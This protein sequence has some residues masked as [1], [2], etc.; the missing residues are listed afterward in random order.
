MQNVFCK[1]KSLRNFDKFPKAFWCTKTT[2]IEN[3]SAVTSQD[4]GGNHLLETIT[5]YTFPA[6]HESTCRL[7][8]FWNIVLR[9]LYYT[10]IYHCYYAYY[11]TGFQTYLP[12]FQPA[13]DKKNFSKLTLSVSVDRRRSPQNHKVY[14]FI[15][16]WFFYVLYKFY[17]Y[18]VFS[19]C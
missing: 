15:W 12:M 18:N 19:I 1:T 3:W 16:T 9:I 10:N 14:Y 2:E 17:N 11:L 7:L 8:I 4:H 13:P 6:C 5:F